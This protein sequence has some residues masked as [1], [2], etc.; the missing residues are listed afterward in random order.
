[1]PGLPSIT[2]AEW[3]VMKALW[4]RAGEWIPAG[5][6]VEPVATARG[7]HHRTARTLLTRLVKKGAVET[8]PDSA[9]SFLYRAKV[10]R[11]AVARAEARSF[12]SRVFDGNAAPALVHL[13]NQ[14]RDELSAAQIKELRNLLS[15]KGKAD[16]RVE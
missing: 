8:R 12:L 6:V 2:D 14:T 11:D 10:S 1:M 7:I 13:L 5:E 15:K 3:H 16:A 9:C 4:D